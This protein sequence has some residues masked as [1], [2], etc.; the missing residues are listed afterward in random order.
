MLIDEEIAAWWRSYYR[1]HNMWS[2]EFVLPEFPAFDP[3]VLAE[4]DR[5]YEQRMKQVVEEDP[6]K[7]K[8]E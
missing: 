6:L 2:E 3:A 8:A 7:P 1:A 4:S 5:E